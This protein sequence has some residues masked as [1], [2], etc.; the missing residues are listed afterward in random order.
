MD[1]KAE[2]IAARIAELEAE[3]EKE[4]SAQLAEKQRQFRYG[5]EKGR[6]AFDAEVAAVQARLRQDSLRFLWHSPRFSLLVSPLI[7]SL[8]VPLL[9]LDAWL[10]AY[11]A[12]C[13][14]VYGIRRVERARYIVLDRRSLPYLN[15]IQRFN[16]DY[17]GYANGLIAYAREVASRTE[18]YFCPI[19]HASRC[20]GPH[21]RYHE[22]AD[23]GDADAYRANWKKLRDEL[24]P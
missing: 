2:K 13:F 7:Y 4:F 3:L 8:I 11:Q 21:L 15:A 24:K 14:R 10:W 5:I 19:K 17:C 12:V 22:F 16:C 18:Q 20:S 9:L 1:H 23:Y 6:V